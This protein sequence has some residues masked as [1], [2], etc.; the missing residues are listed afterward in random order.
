MKIEAVP[1]FQIEGQ[2][3]TYEELPKEKLQEIILKRIDE[4][5]EQLEYKKQDKAP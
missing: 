1:R 5:M 2:Q 3:Y 4:A